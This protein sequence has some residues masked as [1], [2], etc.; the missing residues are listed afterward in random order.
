VHYRHVIPVP[1]HRGLSPVNLAPLTDAGVTPY[2]GL[3]KLRAAGVLGAGWTVAVTGVGGLG[4][5][6]AQY[7]KLAEAGRIKHT[8]TRVRFDDVNET[9]DAV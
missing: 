6:A 2:R 9:I 5:Y 1:A 3:K 7:A 4:S 8:V